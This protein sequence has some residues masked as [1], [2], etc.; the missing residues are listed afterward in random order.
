MG[1]GN[2]VHVLTRWSPYLN[3]KPFRTLVQMAVVA[4]D[5]GDPP[6]YWGGWPPLATALGADFPAL[7][8]KHDPEKCRGKHADAWFFGRSAARARARAR[9]PSSAV[10]L[11]PAGTAL[12]PVPDHQEDLD[13]SFTRS[14]RGGSWRTRTPTCCRG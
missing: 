1:A 12:L 6:R 13:D 2:V 7:C 10:V 4:M 8:G 14:W 11:P 5:E 9:H 3:D